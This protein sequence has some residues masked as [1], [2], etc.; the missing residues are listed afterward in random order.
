[1]MRSKEKQTMRR[2]ILLF[3]LGAFSGLFLATGSAVAQGREQ[4]IK[5]GKKGVVI[6]D[7]ETRVGELILK[8]GSYRLQ[9]RVGASDDFVGKASEE[10]VGTSVAVEHHVTGSEHFIHFEA[11][12]QSNPYHVH[13]PTVKGHPGEVECKLEPLGKKV[14]STTVF[15][16]KEGDVLRVTK[17]EVAGENVAHIF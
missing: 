9:H 7:S 16:I 17:V 14:S 13:S 10:E 1:M 15:G 12:S 4:A 6:F 5:A 8:P 11:L 2:T 3:T